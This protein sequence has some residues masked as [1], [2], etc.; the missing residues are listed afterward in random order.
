VLELGL[1]TPNEG[2]L[3]AIRAK[4]QWIPKADW[5]LHTKLGLERRKREDLALVSNFVC[6]FFDSRSGSEGA[7][8]AQTN[9]TCNRGGAAASRSCCVYLR[10]ST[11]AI[12]TLGSQ[13]ALHRNWR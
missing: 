3:V 8:S 10:L 9:R 5:L 6:G 2:R 11:N 7:S 13:D 4:A 12:H 1:T